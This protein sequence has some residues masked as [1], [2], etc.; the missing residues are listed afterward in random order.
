[1]HAGE[2]GLLDAL[3]ISCAVRVPQYRMEGVALIV[4]RDRVARA[5]DP[6]RQILDR[7]AV[8]VERR[9]TMVES[10]STGRPTASTVSQTPMN[11]IAA[12]RA[13]LQASALKASGVGTGLRGMSGSHW[14]SLA[15]GARCSYAGSFCRRAGP[16]PSA[17]HVFSR[18]RRIPRKA[19][20][21]L[22]W[23]PECRTCGSG[24]PACAP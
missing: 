22:G 3:G 7:E 16:R 6:R 24:R 21:L 15:T 12:L 20:H 23:S 2:P 18:F 10:S 4:D 8:R 13:L 17:H 1:M 11:S 5:L 9:S 19:R 14:L